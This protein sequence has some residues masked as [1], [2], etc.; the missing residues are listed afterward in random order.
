VAWVGAFSSM[1]ARALK[2]VAIASTAA[3]LFYLTLTQRTTPSVIGV[4]SI[5]G[6]RVHLQ[7]V[8]VLFR[9]GARRNSTIPASCAH[10][11]ELCAGT[12]LHTLPGEKVAPAVWAKSLCDI[13]DDGVSVVVQGPNNTPRPPSPH[14]NMQVLRCM[15]TCVVR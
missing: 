10:T 4:S 2:T 12:P 6:R 15:Y 13:P 3:S 8:Q 5:E 1:A 9:H 7:Q 14:D 11:R